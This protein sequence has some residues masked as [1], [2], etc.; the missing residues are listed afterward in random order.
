MLNPEAM[1]QWHLFGNRFL[2]TLARWLYNWPYKDSQ[3]GMWVFKR[4]IWPQLEVRSEGMP[5]SQELKLEAYLKGFRNAE[6]PIEYRVRAGEVK[7]SGIGDPIRTTS[8]LF[9]K[10]IRSVRPRRKVRELAKVAD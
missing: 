9:V 3:S 6:L 10:R 7:L 1:S 4:S 5:F 2:T 8:H